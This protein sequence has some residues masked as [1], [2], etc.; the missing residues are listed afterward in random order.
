VLIIANQLDVSLYSKDFL[1]TR[2]YTL[3]NYLNSSSKDSSELNRSESIIDNLAGFELSGDTSSDKFNKST[4]FL[5]NGGVYFDINRINSKNKDEILNS[6]NTIYGGI[7]DDKIT[8]GDKGDTI[9]GEAGNDTIYGGSGANIIKGGQGNDTL[10]GGSSVDNIYGGDGNDV[11][12]SGEGSDVVYGG[13]GNDIISN[14]NAYGLSG[15]GEE[16]NQIYGGRGADQIKGSYNVNE[17]NYFYAGEEGDYIKIEDKVALK[18]LDKNSEKY[19]SIMNDK[20]EV[21]FYRTG[22]DYIA[23]G[24]GDDTIYGG[25]GRDI[26]ET[27]DGDNKVYGF[28][29]NDFIEVSG[30]TNEVY[31]GEGRDLISV[32]GTSNSVYGEEGDDIILVHGGQNY[33][34]G[35]QGSDLVNTYDNNAGK[36]YIYMGRK[37]DYILSSNGKIELKSLDPKDKEYREVDQVNGGEADDHIYGAYGN[38]ILSGGEGT[39][40]IYGLDGDDV[41]TGGND[42]NHIRGGKG[43]DIISSSGLDYFYFGF[44][45]GHDVISHT[46]PHYGTIYSPE[47]KEST[48]VFDSDVGLKDVS[49]L[50]KFNIFLLSD[51]SK[52]SIDNYNKLKLKF[53]GVDKSSIDVDEFFDF[54]KTYING[55]NYRYNNIESEVRSDIDLFAEYKKF[56]ASAYSAKYRITLGM[57][58]DIDYRFNCTYNIDEKNEEIRLWN[59]SHPDDQKSYVTPIVDGTDKNDELRSFLY[60]GSENNIMHGFEGHDRLYGGLGDD[61]LYGGVGEDRIYGG[62]G[63]DILYGGSDHDIIK[64]GDGDDTIYGGL[65]DDELYGDAGKDKIFGGYGRDTIISEFGYN[66][67]ING[68]DDGDFIKVSSINESEIYGGYGDD[69]IRVDYYSSTNSSSENIIYGGAGDDKIEGKLENSKI[70]G[71]SGNDVIELLGDNNIIEGGDGF[72]Y[73]DANG[74]I[75]GGAKD[76]YII[77]SGNLFGDESDDIIKSKGSVSILDGGTGNDMLYGK[78]GD[79]FNFSIGYGYDTVE[80]FKGDLNISGISLGDLYYNN[81]YLDY[82]KVY[83]DK[84]NLYIKLSSDDILTVKNFGRSNLNFSDLS[85]KLLNREI[86]SKGTDGEDNFNFGGFV[87]GGKGDDSFSNIMNM[88][89][90]TYLF[91]FGDGNDIIRDSN[92]DDTILLKK[93]VTPNDITLIGKRNSLLIKLS[94]G[95]SLEVYD[96]DEESNKLVNIKFMDE[97]YSDIN[98]LE[99]AKNSTTVGDEEDNVLYSF[100]NEFGTHIYG[101]DGDDI[102]EGKNGNDTLDGGFGDDTLKGG[103]GDDS[104][105]FGFG[106]GEDLVLEDLEEGVSNV[107]KIKSNI[108]ADDLAFTNDG[109]SIHIELSDGSTMILDRAF[110]KPSLIEKIVFE[111]GVDADILISDYVA[112]PDNH[113]QGGLEGDITDPGNADNNGGQDSDDTTHQFGLNSGQVEISEESGNDTIELSDGIIIE[114][115]SFK[116]LSDNLE[117]SLSDG[118]KLI[119]NNY[120]LGDEYKVENIKSSTGDVFNLSDYALGLEDETNNNGNPDD[121]DANPPIPTDDTTHQFGLNSGQ[122]EISEESGNDTIE[123]SDGIIIE[124]VSF[125]RLS[126]NLELSLS[127]GSKLIINNYYLGDEYKVENIKSSTGDVFNLSDYAL[128]LEDET[129]NNGN[130]DDGDANPPIP[131]DDTTHQLGLGSG[132]VEVNETAGSDTIELGDGLDV[133]DIEFK[134][135]LN[136]LEL[137]LSDGSTL[138]INGYYDSDEAKVENIK[139]STGDVLDLA[140]YS[141]GL[142]MNGTYGDDVLTGDSEANIFDGQNGADTLVGDLGNDTYL[143]GLNSGANTIVETTETGSSNIIKIKQGITADQLTLSNNGTDVILTLSD[144]SIMT[145]QGGFADPTLIEKIIFEN[146]TDTEILIA[147]YVANPD[148]DNSTSLDFGLAKITGTENNE[149]LSSESDDYGNHLE[150]LGGND[151]L[152]GKDSDDVLDGGTGTDYLNGGSGNDTYIFGFGSGT[153]TITDILGNDTILLNSDVTADDVTVTR[154]KNKLFINLSDGSKLTVSGWTSTDYK[155][156]TLKFANGVD[157]DVDLVELAKNTPI[158]GTDRYETIYADSDEYGSHLRGFENKDTLNG[159]AGDDTLDGG[160]GTD[161]LNGGSGN[162]TYIFG[163]GYGNDAI[164]DVLGNDT[165]LLSSDVTASDVTVTREKNKLLITLSDGSKLTVNSWTSTD[166]KVETLKFANGVDADINLVELA[167]TTPIDGT[168]NTNYMYADSNE[169]GSHMRGLGGTDIL[170]GKDGNDILDGGSG[171]DTLNGDDG[172]DTYIFG[173]GFGEDTISER[174]GNDVIVLKEDVSASDVTIT[175]EMSYL[176]ITLSDGSKLKVS[177]WTTNGKKVETLKFANGVDADIDLVELAKTTP[178]DGT[179]NTNYMYAD[180]NKFGS[181]MRGLGGTDILNGK[182]GDD[183]LDGGAGNDTLNGDDGDDILIGGAGDDTLFGKNGNDTLEG[184]VGDDTLSCGYG[185]DILKGGEDN[186]T[187]NY[188]SGSGSDQIFE[189]SGS[190][191]LYVGSMDYRTLWFS[192]SGSDLKVSIIGTNDDI[193]VKGWYDN[194]ANK[195]EEIETY[196]KECNVEGINLLVQAMAGFEQPTSGTIDTNMS[197]DLAN[198]MTQAWQARS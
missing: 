116:R 157:A 141:Q 59:E 148:G 97:I 35:G 117:L 169:F 40:K 25:Y 129:N 102:L 81:L 26:I 128:G 178:I 139:L 180:S 16:I 171:N 87:D 47:Y 55:I 173:F 23:G 176:I 32:D 193:T 182:D 83:M 13:D 145:I 100:S 158:D 195:V 149:T 14:V 107:I 45:D 15:A 74:T 98:L 92:I 51:G 79:I 110:S 11:I 131:T 61:E 190:D 84:S 183:I 165:I 78:E 115:V 75:H 150:G 77:G 37:E 72:D 44:G 3:K 174:S 57:Y 130:P 156:E 56:G 30:G 76:D 122:V 111:N 192:K 5:G 22:N 7:G 161:Y 138:K 6:K 93:G 20:I 73:I 185:D 24:K 70:D 126:D 48:I 69:L 109:Y 119:I 64:G 170:N 127:D 63:S 60:N 50:D 96:W 95:S 8:G 10:Y 86:L 146:G 152:R 134:R 143:F 101:L 49:F 121:G 181:H 91:G 136:N 90:Y 21:D 154:E 53:D 123:L 18:E 188:T 166:Y 58:H 120:Y 191:L 54:K 163:F 71:G 34:Y 38:D 28:D 4:L 175:R 172:D 135:V 124:D 19:K 82:D 67:Y 151:T 31:G 140:P 103:L 186:D 99:L 2:V 68:E 94:D 39:N 66:Q 9:Y 89:S 36:K 168:P 179:P 52:I 88:S 144:G 42:E 12:N 41:I 114:D 160:T 137:S 108:N 104:Y 46:L 112:N 153:D 155:V 27:G 113:N 118:S 80:A 33:I 125:K 106:Y 164:T 17:K 189:T 184:G 1:N 62:A 142:T 65:G 29:G 177:A 196:N 194:D 197:E 159:K 43:N 133:S 147:D 187:Y 198:A 85:K 162:D 132:V 105:V 167:K